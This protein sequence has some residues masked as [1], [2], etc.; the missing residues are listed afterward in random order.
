MSCFRQVRG[1][2]APAG[3]M[4]I[5]VMA[6]SHPSS[7]IFTNAEQAV[8]LV[9]VVVVTRQKRGGLRR[10]PACCQ[11]TNPTN[12]GRRLHVIETKSTTPSLVLG[13]RAQAGRQATRGMPRALGLGG[14]A[15][16]PAGCGPA[17]RAPI[18][19]N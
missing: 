2:A 11:P 14:V 15:G 5:A 7:S 18:I 10:G 6:S 8:V 9:V 1:R 4:L 3:R 12:P 16:R 17:S 13:G 19:A